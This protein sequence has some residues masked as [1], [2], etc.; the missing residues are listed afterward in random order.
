VSQSASSDHFKKALLVNDPSIGI[1]DDPLIGDK[2]LDCVG[3]VFD[4]CLRKLLFELQQFFFH[5]SKFPVVFS[6]LFS[7]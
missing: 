3:I 2:L 6:M 1:D 5:S 7:L 4:D